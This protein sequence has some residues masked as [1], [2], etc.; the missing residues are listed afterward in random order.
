MRA[1][2]IKSGGADR[3]QGLMGN[4]AFKLVHQKLSFS[5]YCASVGLPDTYLLII[6]LQIPKFS[7]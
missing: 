5:S 7:T 2:E 3:A 1:S 4:V 6:N